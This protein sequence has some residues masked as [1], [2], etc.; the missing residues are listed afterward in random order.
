MQKV[1]IVVQLPEDGEGY[2]AI[3]KSFSSW[4][5]AN[6]YINNEVLPDYL[7]LM[8]DRDAREFV[9]AYYEILEHEVRS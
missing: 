3:H 4:D 8:E 2:T 9:K 1:Y 5:A 7:K 6:E